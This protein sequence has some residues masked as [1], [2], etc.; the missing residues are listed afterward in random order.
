MATGKK[1]VIIVV[2][3]FDGIRHLDLKYMENVFAKQV[4]NVATG[5]DDIPEYQ[6][7][8]IALGFVDDLSK[9]DVSDA[10]E[11]YVLIAVKGLLLPVI[12]DNAKRF[13]NVYTNNLEPNN[14]TFEKVTYE[15]V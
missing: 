11:T 14:Y 6:S 5:F 2:A 8:H 12:T 3:D 13:V 1:P 7:Y 15:N 10:S 9:L 4:L